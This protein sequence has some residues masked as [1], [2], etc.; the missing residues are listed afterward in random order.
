VSKILRDPEEEAE[1]QAYRASVTK[2]EAERGSMVAQAEI[3]KYSDDQPRDDH[4][5]WT[6]G[7]DTADAYDRESLSRDPSYTRTP[8]VRSASEEG[9]PFNMGTPPPGRP[10]YNPDPRPDEKETDLKGRPVGPKSQT[11][12]AQALKDR[13]LRIGDVVEVKQG[14]SWDKWRV[15]LLSRRAIGLGN[16]NETWALGRTRDGD[17]PIRWV[18][19]GEGP[20]IKLP[21]VDVPTSLYD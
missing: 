17:T 13:A 20:K 2:R 11:T 16:E 18:S 19:H 9:R 12:A 8:S 6:S 21:P 5:R 4:G 3:A 7:G 1:Y 14:S 15:E 10:L